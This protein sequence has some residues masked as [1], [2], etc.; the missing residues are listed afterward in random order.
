MISTNPGSSSY[1]GGARCVWTI[2]QPNGFGAA[3]VFLNF[4]TV[5]ENDNF[6]I[7]SSS[8]A[9]INSTLSGSYSPPPDSVI[10]RPGVNVSISFTSQTDTI[11]SSGVT[12]LLL[13]T[14][15]YC[16]ATGHYYSHEDSTIGTWGNSLKVAANMTMPITSWKGHL[17]TITS[18][19]ENDCIYQLLLSRLTRAGTTIQG[20]SVWIAGL[21]FFLLDL[22][23]CIF[24]EFTSPEPKSKRMLIISYSI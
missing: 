9:L 4:S 11:G 5:L 21:Y 2:D 15:L 17:A 24:P 23:G 13:F 18:M 16:E 3:I 12:V 22:R 19:A 8:S 6:S 7:T 14:P 10:V 20:S 1:G